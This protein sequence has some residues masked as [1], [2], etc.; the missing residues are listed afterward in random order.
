MPS[1]CQCTWYEGVNEV[2]FIVADTGMGVKAHLRQTYPTISDDLEALR[3]SL[4]PKVS[5]TFGRYDPYQA[6]NNAGM[7]LFLSSNI[8][9]RLGAEM[10]LV[11]GSGV[12]H[13]TAR[14]ITTRELKYGWPGTFALVTVKLDRD[15]EFELHKMMQE[16]REAANSEQKTADAV[17]SDETYYLSIFN[18]FGPNAEVKE[19]AVRHRDKYLLPAIDQG[20][21]ILIDFDQVNSAPHSFL[22]ALVA[23][24][25]KRLG[26]SAYKRLRIINATPEIRETIDFIMDENTD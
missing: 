23:T 4:R 18:Y 21:K 15:A 8:V 26:M 1:I 24:P 6:K 11:S 2:H 14:D 10:Y 25:V 3:A 7:G 13:V 19:E 17:E 12:I 20:K 5:G 9:R 16:F 22:S